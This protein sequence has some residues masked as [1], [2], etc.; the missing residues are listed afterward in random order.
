MQ[1][2]YV[3]RG[4]WETNPMRSMHPCEAFANSS[5]TMEKQAFPHWHKKSQWSVSK[6]NGRFLEI[7]QSICQ[8]RKFCVSA[9]PRKSYLNVEHAMLC[10]ERKESHEESLKNVGKTRCTTSRWPF[11][12]WHEKNTMD[13][14][15]KM[16]S[17]SESF[18]NVGK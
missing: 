13:G 10:R 17:F 9:R 15:H 14:F 5:K 16:D 7:L 3:R 12:H 8:T 11:Q 1:Q 6:N 4:P 2:R 18:K